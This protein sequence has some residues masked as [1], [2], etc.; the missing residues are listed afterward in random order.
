MAHSAFSVAVETFELPT[1]VLTCE[2]S[3]SPRSLYITRPERERRLE[4]IHQNN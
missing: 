1:L 2:S 4:K 3:I